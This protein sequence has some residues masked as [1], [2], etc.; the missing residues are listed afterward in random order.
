MKNREPLLEN[1]FDYL[2]WIDNELLFAVILT[3]KKER[4]LVGT[5]TGIMEHWARKDDSK[6]NA[7][8]LSAYN[9]ECVRDCLPEEKTIKK[10]ERFFVDFAVD[11]L[12]TAARN[13]GERQRYED[14][15]Q[16]PLVNDRTYPIGHL[17]LEF[18][19]DYDKEWNKTIS[20]L[21]GAMKI[22]KK[23]GASV[24]EAKDFLLEKWR[25]K[26]P[27]CQYTAL[28]IW[29]K[30]CQT[31]DTEV[32][33]RFAHRLADSFWQNPSA[34]PTLKRKKIAYDDPILRLGVNMGIA[35]IWK[36]FIR[37]GNWF[38]RQLGRISS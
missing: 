30:F 23:K 31:T 32:F 14:S 33:E 28:S 17:L 29:K 3:K 37:V 16:I 5:K 24:E 36:T 26:D 18:E 4:I 9:F 21:A 20:K 15:V 34:T 8:L 11:G 6:E 2:N 27:V 12:M 25:S 7:G 22:G 13:V 35:Y 19:R 10:V 1:P 38:K